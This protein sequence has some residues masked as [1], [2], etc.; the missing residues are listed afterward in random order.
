MNLLT[1]KTFNLINKALVT[2]EWAVV[3]ITIVNYFHNHQVLCDK[4]HLPKYD[5]TLHTFN[6]VEQ[7]EKK[8]FLKVIEFYIK[9]NKTRRGNADFVAHALM[10]MDQF[11]VN[12]DLDVYKAI[13]NVFPKG[14]YIPENKY[15]AMLHHYPKHQSVT[16]DL[17]VKMEQNKVMPD[18]DMQQMIINIFGTSSEP[19][20]RLWRMMYWMPKFS[21]LDPWPLP[22]PT[23]TDVRVLAQFALQKLSSVDVQA[24]ITQYDTKNV[25]DAVDDTWIISSI[26]KSQ[27]ELLAVQPINKSLIVE[28]PFIIWVAD[29]HLNYF[30]L[31]GNP[32]ERE[33]IYES[34][35]D[36][37]NLQIPFWEKHHIKIPVTIHEQSDGVYYAMCSTG[38]SSKDSL[39]SWIRC[40]QKT[41]PILEKIPI[42]FKIK[43]IV[44]KSLCIEDKSVQ[45][46][47][48]ICKH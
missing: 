11:R 1:K 41:N 4:K 23:P 43:S 35:D 12:K 5:V 20:K 30:V 34:Y 36:V 38:T 28:G 32:I 8:A 44:E 3:Q 24:K 15:Q 37:S 45:E 33:I 31:K 18:Y 14:P 25:Q 19:I 39:L 40:L 29:Q 7:K 2:K 48:P 46:S 21:K 17:L 10:Y 16:M 26:S 9:E 13:L 27:Q 22:K 47:K 6:A 42:T